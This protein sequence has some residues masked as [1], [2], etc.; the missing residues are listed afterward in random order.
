MGRE[1]KEQI[2][3]DER[4]LLEFG[5]TAKVVG[6]TYAVFVHGIKVTN[7]ST[8]N[9]KEAIEKATEE[10][11]AIHPD[12]KIVHIAWPRKAIEAKKVYSSMIVEVTTPEA[13]NRMIEIGYIEGAEVRTCELFE[14]GCKLT[15]CFKCNAFGHVAK[16]CKAKER[17]GF[18][19]GSH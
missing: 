6:D 5:K 3:R 4:W 13:A 18:C 7:V 11:K 16:V 9:Q 8:D 14:T 12:A 17:C 15:Q 1:A 2:L 19:A 10:N